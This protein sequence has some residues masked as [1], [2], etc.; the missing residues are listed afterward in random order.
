MS[1][2]IQ[3]LLA[4]SLGGAVGAAGRYLIMIGV[5]HWFGHGFPFGTLLVNIAGSFLL[6]AMIETSAL[7][8]SPSPEIRAFI[9]VGVLGAFTTFSAFSLDAYTLW[10][11]GDVMAAIGY[12]AA[13]IVFGILALLAGLATLRMLL[14]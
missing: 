8:W 4:V 12:V 11:R 9:V 14:S 6:G 1:M 2:S 5:G 7:V 13:S 3:H 10:V